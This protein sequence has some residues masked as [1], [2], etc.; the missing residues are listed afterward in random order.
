MKINNNSKY[1]PY[2]ILFIIF[3]LIRINYVLLSGEI[4]NI[5]FK[6]L[7]ISNCFW[8]F[9]VIKQTAL[10][11][12]FM[13]FYY[14]IIGIF[15]NEILIKIFNTLISLAN[16]YIFFL[17]GKKIHSD[18]LGI[19]L[20]LFLS[21][22]HFFL[23]YSNLIAPYC[24]IFLIHSCLVYVLFDYLKKPNKKSYVYL[25]LLNCL[26][27]IIDTFGFVFVVSELLFL[28]IIGKRR[29]IYLKQASK[30]FSAS[31]IC[32]MISFPIL[33]TQYIVNSKLVIPNTF[34]SIGLNLNA[35]YLMLSEYVSPF[36]SFLAPETQTKSTL[37]L[38]Y[39]FFLNP[40]IKNLNSLKILITLFYSSILPILVMLWLT[41]R[42]YKKNYRLKII[43]LIC[44]FNFVVI[45]CLMLFEKIEV[46]PIYAIQ[47][48]VISVI[49]LG[50]GIFTLK[51]IV[52]KSILI[53]CLLLIQTINPE[54]SAF[55]ITVK[56]NFSTISPIK[57]FIKDFVVTKDDTIIMPHNGRFASLYFKKQK[58]LN[59]DDNYLR[60][61]R[62]QSIIRNISSK[63]TKSINKRNVAYLVKEFL[64]ENRVN[65]YLATYFTNE[66]F[67]KNDASERYIL[68]IDKLNSKPISLNSISKYA[69]QKDY[70]WHPRK[71][72]YR[73]AD[74]GQNPSK[75]LYDAL[76]SK[77]IYNLV[78]ILN[79]NFELDSI[80]E[81]KKIDNEYYKIASSNNISK[82]INS[83]DSD[84]VFLIFK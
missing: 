52:V 70:S 37:G 44:A 35:V 69:N 38:L 50:Y 42:V 32:F 83:Y 34:D 63:K 23:Y 65:S 4:E 80:V 1:V 28:N 67:N 26:L 58:V 30:L 6:G 66:I 54:L 45:L 59:Y 77:T 79:S 60:F 24:L 76:K 40:D 48:F 68:V 16:I 2:I 5:G 36:L 29:K 43:W 81:Y 61:S 46:Q 12:V 10:C 39:G 74:I 19:F 84:Y 62:K 64:L 72:D 51:D 11:D 13:P 71:I 53:I 75:N 82:A 25:N 41:I 78:G 21:I 27:I 20:G 33:L 14:L 8:P 22:N 3:I 73:Y 17:I 31:F 15:K 18:K 57:I 47:F 49:I 56:K 9:E 7:S 55:D